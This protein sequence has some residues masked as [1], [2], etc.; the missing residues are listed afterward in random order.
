MIFRDG[1]EARREEVG[2]EEKHLCE[3]HKDWLPRAR[4][5]TGAGA[6]NPQPGTCP[7]PGIQPAT[8]WGGGMRSNHC[9]HQPGLSAIVKWAQGGPE[10]Y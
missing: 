1:R 9:A 3:K 4:T 7:P 2:R 8:L 10:G 6:L 5:P